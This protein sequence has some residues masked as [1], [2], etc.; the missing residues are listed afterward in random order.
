MEAYKPAV[1]AGSTKARVETVP[2]DHDGRYD[3]GMMKLTGV[4]SLPI[5][6]TGD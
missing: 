1:E 2:H 4:L 3:L 6:K 5:K